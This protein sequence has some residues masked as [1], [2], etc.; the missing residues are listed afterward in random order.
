MINQNNNITFAS[1]LSITDSKCFE[2]KQKI[3]DIL[4]DFEIAMNL[5]KHTG[6]ICIIRSAKEELKEIQDKIEEFQE[7]ELSLII[8]KLID[9]EGNEVIDDSFKNRD[10]QIMLNS[11]KDL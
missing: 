10:R 1:S 3:N 9:E 8:L 5:S 11:Y 6:N 7:D 4:S 2:L